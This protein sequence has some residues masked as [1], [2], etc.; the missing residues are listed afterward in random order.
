MDGPRI[1]VFDLETRVGPEHLDIDRERGWDKLR[2]GEGGIS[3]LAIFDTSQDWTYLYDDFDILDVAEHLEA[4]D[5]VVGYSSSR[6]DLLVIEGILRRKLVIKRHIDLYELVKTGLAKIH[7]PQGK[8]ENTLGA[9]CKRTVGR[10]KIDKGEF[11]SELVK[12]GKYGRVFRYCS[13]D[14]HLTW[15]LFKHMLR[16]QSFVNINSVET[17][18]EIPVDLQTWLYDHEK[19]S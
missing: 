2:R 16:N 10:G 3:A 12:L 17:R 18:V 5:V 13:D 19:R 15:D 9:V 14:V 1:C 8:G 4:A 11:V 6:F 7:V